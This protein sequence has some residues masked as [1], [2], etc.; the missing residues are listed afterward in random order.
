[1]AELYFEN[2][3]TKKRYTVI[4]FDRNAGT[5]TLRGEHGV[6]FTEPYDKERFQQMG[7]QLK[8]GD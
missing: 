6:D 4:R 5:V 2:E 1:M 3:K 7:Y 8:Q